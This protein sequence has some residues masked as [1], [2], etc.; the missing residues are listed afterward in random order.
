MFDKAADFMLSVSMVCVTLWIVNRFWNAFFEKKK[1]SFLSIMIW[2]SFTVFQLFFERNSGNIHIGITA[3]N[4]C[5]FLLVCIF[6]YHSSG[7][8]KYFLLILFYAVW[9]LLE[10]FAFFFI[11]IILPEEQPDIIGEVISK[12]LMLIFVH[13]LSVAQKVK[14]ENFIPNR[15]YALLLLIPFGSICIAIGEFYTKENTYFPIITI[16]ILLMFNV[17]I[18]EVYTK[19][20]EI[21][22]YEREL[23]VYAQK[24]EIISKSTEAQEK[25][26]KEF[27]EEKHDL[28]NKL[29][30]LKNNIESDEEKP[31]ILSSIDK[32]ID[33]PYRLEVISNSG[34]TTIDAIINFKYAAAKEYGII[35]Q[36]KIFV[37]S[38]LPIK[39]CDIGVVLGN[40][41]DNA[42]DAAKKCSQNAKVIEVS[43]GVKKNAWIVV[44]RNPFEHELKRDRSGNFLSTKEDKQQHGFG[45]NSIKKVVERYQGEVIT[46]TINHIF[47]LTIVMNLGNFDSR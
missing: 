19:L 41:I 31:N 39:Q 23:A 47:S 13:E 18:L 7:K 37:P 14:R 10:I 5:L 38:K 8:A 12:I 30:V 34:N 6:G 33:I 28:I 11:Q 46:E 44:I 21:F 20:N 36:L 25:M 35:F 17:I 42:I 26:M 3:V 32:I 2:I 15:Y 16:S 45:L 24:V 9:S 43:I 29:I 40:A 1:K 4:M 22:I 27:H